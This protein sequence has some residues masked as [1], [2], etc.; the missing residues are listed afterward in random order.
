MAPA[1][2]KIYPMLSKRVRVSRQ[3]G[4]KVA[5]LVPLLLLGTSAGLSQQKLE[6]AQDTNERL[7]QL[8]GALQVKQ[9]DYV[10]GGGD[11]LRI[12]VFD[13]PELSRD[14]RVGSSGF[15]SLPLLPTRVRAGGLT[16][17]QLEE[18]VAELLQANGLVSHPQV[19][20][21]VREQHSQP[22]TVTGAVA[23]PLVYQAVRQTTLL[24]VLTEAG[25]IAADA[26]STVIVTRVANEATEGEGEGSG[27]SGGA[28]ATRTTITLDLGDLLESGD[29][30]FNIPLMGGDVVTVP[31][32]GIVYVVGAV[33][34]QGGFV[35]A[36][37]REQMTTIKMLALAG[38]LKSTAK[39]HQAVI[40]RRSPDTG[41]RKEINV[42][43]AKIMGRKAE[44]VRLQA[45]D[46]LFVPDSKGK[47]ALRRSGEVAVA[48]VS[49]LALFR[50]TR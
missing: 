7:R 11:F 4:G 24:E 1:W 31:R 10:I 13:V 49:G 43:L 2:G 20:V 36:N 30:K 47:K 50:L 28:P 37:D 17:F 3:L 38:G 8:A 42:D 45:S 27:N 34:K 19:T 26:G 41:L 35:L 6:T 46:I 48:L 16:A 44:D 14:V 32:A 9:G 18:K 22:I 21:L 40:L 23:H 25:G 29:M 12:D 15:I 39:P 5:W 33:D